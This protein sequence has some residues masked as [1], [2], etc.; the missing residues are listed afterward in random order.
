MPVFLFYLP[1]TAKKRS[2]RTHH[3]MT[4]LCYGVVCPDGGR[5]LYISAVG[6]NEAAGGNEGLS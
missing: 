6:G 1:P 2:I 5:Y 3:A 4:L